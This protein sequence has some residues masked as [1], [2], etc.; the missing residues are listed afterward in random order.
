MKKAIPIWL[1]N[2]ALADIDALMKGYRISVEEQLVSLVSDYYPSMIAGDG[3]E[4]RKMLELS[5]KMTMVGRA[6]AEIAGFPF[7][8]R[9]LRISCLFGACCFLG[10]SFLDDFGDDDSR[11]YLQRYELLLTKGWFE[12]RNQREQL[13]Y[14]ILSRLFGERDVLDVM[15][16]QAI[17]GLFLSQKR[18]VEMRA[19][20][21][22]F[23]ATPRHRQLRL[24]K[25][26]ARDRS[27]HAITILS[28]FLVPELPL[29]YQHLLYTAGALIMY[30]DDHG[31]CHYDRY[32]NRI[33]YM[34]QVKHPVQ[35]LRR[36]FNT[37]IDRLYTRLPESEGRELLIGFLYRYFVTRL[38]KHRLERNSGKFSW[39]VY[40]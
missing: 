19:C 5:S 24:L 26:C 38:E 12:I 22:S 17:F 23:K 16:R 25:E 8:T 11:E 32:Y 6:C 28:L 9:R 7:D 27:G 37:S 13:F 31:D 10:D 40:E 35:T 36:I 21:P 14:I 3:V 20:S 39:N 18:D 15:L 34:N 30:I 2:K 33:T 1:G 4:Y 29:L